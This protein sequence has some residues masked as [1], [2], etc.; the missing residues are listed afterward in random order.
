M[1][2]TQYAFAAPNTASLELGD[3]RPNQTSTYNFSVSNLNTGQNIACVE[4]DLGTNAD[5]TGAISGL[6]TS[7]STLNSNSIVSGTTVSNTQSANHVLRA[8]KATPSAPSASGSVVFGAVTNGSTADTSYFAVFTTYSDQACTTSV[9]SITVQFIYTNGQTVTVTVDPSFTFSVNAVTAGTGAQA[10]NGQDTTV[11]TTA[12][13]I[14]FGTTSASGNEVGAQDLQISTNA[15]G[16]YNIYMRQT[17]P[18]TNASSDTI[19]AVSGSNACTYAAPASFPAAGTEA[20][21]FTTNDADIS[22]GNYAANNW[23]DVTGTN[24]SVG[25][26]SVATSGTQTVRVGYQV[27]VSTTTEAGNYS[28]TIIYTAVPTY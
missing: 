7:S 13:T 25:S 22:S 6:N 5:G 17:G 1:S 24:Q 28:N 18:L 20:F 3:S 15:Q 12:T 19:N 14:P 9:E 23:C 2:M 11:T 8:T 27:G 21:G 26:G 16:G 10:V 4:I